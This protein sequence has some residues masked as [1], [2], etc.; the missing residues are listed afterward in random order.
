MRVVFGE[1]LAGLAGAGPEVEAARF[2]GRQLGPADAL[3]LVRSR[4]APRSAATSTAALT[5]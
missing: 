1:R 5:P 4:Q 3:E 2:A